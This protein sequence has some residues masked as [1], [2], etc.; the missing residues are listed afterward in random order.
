M[1][2][3]ILGILVLF[4]FCL[5]MGETPTYDVKFVARDIRSW[6]ANQLVTLPDYLSIVTEYYPND[7]RIVRANDI[8]SFD[9]NKPEDKDILIV[10]RE[11]GNNEV[12]TLSESYNCFI[13]WNAKNGNT[14]Y[15]YGFV[16]GLNKLK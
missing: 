8:A 14:Y 13:L 15:V 3:I 16:P 12:L 1:K 5:A 6:N 10:W 9:K 7:A 2:K 11:T 4:S